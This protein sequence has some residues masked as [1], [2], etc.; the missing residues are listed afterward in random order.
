M[1]HEIISKLKSE[2]INL[3]KKYRVTR[4]GLFGSYARGEESP[5]SDVDILIE[6]EDVPGMKEFFGAEEYLEN[7]LNK[8]VDLVRQEALRPELRERIMSGV[9]YI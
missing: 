3:H 9:V 1:N 6:F 4:L 5:G 7:L 8:K 2:K